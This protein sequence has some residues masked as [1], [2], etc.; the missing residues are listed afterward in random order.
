V[1]FAYNRTSGLL[2]FTPRQKLAV[3]RHTV[4]LVA[5]DARGERTVEAWTFALTG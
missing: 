5:A 2:T 3:G 4:R 1:N